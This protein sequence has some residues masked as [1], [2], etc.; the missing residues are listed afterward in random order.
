MMVLSHLF[1]LNP[2]IRMRLFTPTLR[3]ACYPIGFLIACVCLL[4]MPVQ[5]QDTAPRTVS[6]SRVNTSEPL[7]TLPNRP[8]LARTGIPAVVPNK[9]HSFADKGQRPEVTDLA[10]PVIDTGAASRSSSAT[11]TVVQSFAGI[12]QSQSPFIF[13][14]DTNGDVGP[15]HY[16][17]WINGTVQFY[18]KQGS[19]LLGPVSGNFFWQGLGGLC[20]ARNDGDPIILYDEMADRWVAMQFMLSQLLNGFG[21]YALCFAVS[22]TPDPTGAYHQYEFPF[23]YFP[24][25]PK[26]GV[27]SDA[28]YATANIFFDGDFRQEA[29]AFEREAMLQGLPA[30]AVVFTIPSA[31][32]GSFLPADA[33]G[34]APPAGTPGLFPGRPDGTALEIFALDVNWT[35]PSASTFS[36]LDAPTVASHNP[37]SGTVPQPS[38]GAG[39]E[40][41]GDR[42]MHRAQYRNFGDRQTL[43]LNHT[44]D[45]QPGFS[46]RAGI[47]WY[48][49]RNGAGNS[50]SGWGLYQQGTY[51]PDDG[52]YRW[53]GSV[54]MNGAGDIAVGYSVSGP[55][56]FPAIRFA[57]QTADQS[58]TGVLNVPETEIQTGG[59]VQTGT[60][61]GRSRWG[62]YS[63][64]SVDPS[65]DQTFWYTTEYMPFTSTNEYSTRIAELAVDSGIS[66]NF[67]LT[68]VNTSPGGSPIIVAA[69]GSVTFDYS[70]SNNT[71]SAASGDL[72][73]TASLG[74][75]TV[76][77]MLV[78]SGMV[79]GGATVSQSFVQPV[80]AGAPA[81]SYTYT[82]S[83]GQFPSTAVD[84][85]TFDLQ[86]TTSERPDGAASWAVVDAE[87]WGD[88]EQ[89]GPA[90]SSSLPG[91]FALGAAYPNPFTQAAILPVVL[92]DAAEVR[93]VVF[94]VLG[95]EVAVLAEGRLEAGK[96][97]LVFDATGLPSGAY[98]ARLTTEAGLSQTQRLTLLR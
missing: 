4:A 19:T 16:V 50:G 47:R 76:A 90:L 95:R 1:F 32:R 94:D 43:V 7:R 68:A 78:Q 63:M 77:Q 30:D 87:A 58:G 22:T 97:R 93:V 66:P 14:P 40:V 59:G 28:Y 5:A 44:V 6:A 86:I 53:M 65:D 26:V 72:W 55:S 89:V 49:L 38:P 20:D 62:D 88:A 91:T 46:D 8:G 25:Y 56:L 70:V 3:P 83:M 82:L 33:D 57:A 75:S 23:S 84:T 61:G 24:D 92:P 60:F 67:D 10:D 35:T 11:G 48:E 27:W 52:L 42:L 18:D 15:N 74:G 45:V 51:A 85:E 81:G 69:G 12:P 9:L 36:L 98:V 96:H 41:L 37:Y 2:L 34:S 17:Q 31:T 29:M 39:L 64:M 73:Y 79:A 13:P 54:A 71:G 21:G 80:P